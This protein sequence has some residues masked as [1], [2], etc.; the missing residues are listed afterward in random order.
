MGFCGKLWAY[1]AG[2]R[3]R[4]KNKGNKKYLTD[5]LLFIFRL[6]GSKQSNVE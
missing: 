3:T 5:L 6:Q 4:M 2:E 1:P